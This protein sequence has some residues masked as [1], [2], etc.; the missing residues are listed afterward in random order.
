ML[1]VLVRITG[2]PRFERI[3]TFESRTKAGAIREARKIMAEEI[4]KGKTH[5]RTLVE[6]GCDEC[7]EHPRERYRISAAGEAKKLTRR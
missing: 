1:N 6:I 7:F 3:D 4:R 2:T 5:L